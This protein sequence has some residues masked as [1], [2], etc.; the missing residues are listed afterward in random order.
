MNIYANIQ[1]VHVDSINFGIVSESAQHLLLQALNDQNQAAIDECLATEGVK[2]WIN[3]HAVLKQL[4]NPIR[5]FK[6]VTGITCLA[7]ASV[8]SDDATVRQ[9]VEA[10]ADITA[11]DSRGFSPLHYA[12]ASDVDA[13]AKVA[14]LMRRGVPSQIA[15]GG[16]TQTVFGTEF[17]ATSLRLAAWFNQ[18]DRVRAL[19]DNHGVPVNSTDQQGRTALFYAATSGNAEAVNVLAS[20]P[21]CDF[22]FTDTEGNTLAQLVRKLGHTDIAAMIEIKFKGTFDIYVFMSF[23]TGTVYV[24][25]CSL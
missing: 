10:G 12:C 9:L 22:S 11:T 20:H 8:V 19:L 14:Y 18:A 23:K 7:F 6:G 3:R 17:Y 1:R 15:N 4:D 24:S 21:Y 16:L 5:Q 2:D 25:C 13:D